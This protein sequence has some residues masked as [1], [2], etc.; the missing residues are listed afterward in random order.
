MPGTERIL[1]SDHTWSRLLIPAVLVLLITWIILVPFGF[2][3]NSA[4]F[5][6][7]FGVIFFS[8]CY[9]GC[10]SALIASITSA[11]CAF[12]FIYPQYHQKGADTFRLVNC[13]FPDRGFNG[14]R[15][16]RHY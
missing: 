3:G 14:D 12:L 11:I 4:P 5:L 9:G 13:I 7:Y 16:I 10:R 8:A 1:A 2:I 15:F 6:A